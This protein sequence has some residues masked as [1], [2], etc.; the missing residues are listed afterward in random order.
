MSGKKIL[1]GIRDAVVGN[2]SRVTIDGQT[3]VRVPDCPGC[4]AVSGG[5]LP[6]TLHFHH[7][8]C[9]ERLK[10]AECGGTI[11]GLFCEHLSQQVGAICADCANT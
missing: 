10:C 9:D 4:A 1:D 11:E 2:L 6:N 5:R 7:P 8:L 3:W